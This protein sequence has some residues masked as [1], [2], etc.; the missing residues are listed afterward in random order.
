MQQEKRAVR[1]RFTAV[2]AELKACVKSVELFVENV[3]LEKDLLQ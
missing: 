3:M 1:K 2:M